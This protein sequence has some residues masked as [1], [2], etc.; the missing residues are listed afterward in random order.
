MS[1]TL[2]EAAEDVPNAQ[3]AKDATTEVSPAAAGVTREPEPTA[4]AAVLDMVAGSGTPYTTTSSSSSHP[5]SSSGDSGSS[6]SSG[7]EED[8]DEAAAALGTVTGEL[9]PVGHLPWRHSAVGCF[10][11]GWVI[12]VPNF[13]FTRNDLDLTRPSFDAL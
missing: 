8:N 3:D 1:H 12:A 10:H 4:L 9:R 11:C 5:S 13:E 2:L 7:S 6:S